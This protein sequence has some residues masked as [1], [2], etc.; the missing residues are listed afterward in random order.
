MKVAA[1]GRVENKW[2][3]GDFRG[4]AAKDLLF[5]ALGEEFGF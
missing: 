5:V 2:F 1:E 4:S 3:T